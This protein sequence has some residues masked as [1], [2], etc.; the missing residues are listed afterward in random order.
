MIILNYKAFAHKQLVAFTISAPV[1][2]VLFEIFVILSLPKEKKPWVFIFVA[3]QGILFYLICFAIYSYAY[4]IVKMNEQSIRCR[5]ISISWEDIQKIELKE[6]KM[7]Q[8]SLLPTI[9]YSSMSY[10]YG[11]NGEKIGIAMTKRNL[12]MIVQF[13][14][15]KSRKIL[16][17]SEKIKV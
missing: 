12:D 13:G 11:S 3:A 8:H 4:K 10:I 2:F 5:K 16:E 7:M 9:T 15:D 17:L 6:I 14:K 1:M